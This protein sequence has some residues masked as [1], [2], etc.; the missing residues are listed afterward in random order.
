[1]K[2]NYRSPNGSLE[3][4]YLTLLIHLEEGS[5]W[6]SLH[7]AP[8]PDKLDGE[9]NRWLTLLLASDPDKLDE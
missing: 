6:L 9:G 1:M 4:F 3:P 8:L 2:H 5:C 7:L